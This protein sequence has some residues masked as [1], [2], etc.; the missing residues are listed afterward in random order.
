MEPKR[1]WRKGF[2]KQKSSKT[3]EKGRG[4]DKWWQRRWGLWRGD[5]RKMRWTN[6]LMLVSS[7]QLWA[8]AIMLLA[9]TAMH[10]TQQRLFSCR[11][12]LKTA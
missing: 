6:V 11:W 2:V 3:T 9:L 4:S 12:N 8:F 7:S 1:L 10:S 5:A